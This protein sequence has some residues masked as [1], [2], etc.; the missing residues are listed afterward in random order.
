VERHPVFA[1]S[2]QFV[3]GYAAHRPIEA[4]VSGIP[5]HDHAW[6]DLSPD[7]HDAL[8]AWLRDVLDELA[9][10][11]AATTHEE[12][13]AVHVLEELVRSDLDDHEHGEH[14]RDLS[15]MDGT[16]PHVR[17]ALLS[18]DRTVPQGWDDTLARL[19]TLPDAL[20]GYR[21]T[22]QQGQDAGRWAAARQAESIVSQLR[23]MAGPEGAIRGLLDAHERAGGTQVPHAELTTAATGAGAACLALADDLEATYLPH[24]PTTDGVGE[25]RYLRAARHHLGMDLDPHEAYAWGWEHLA[26]L[27][28]RMRR[29]VA[30]IDPD[31]DVASVM[32]R[33]K[34]DPAH[35]AADADEF[36]RV[37]HARLADAVERLDGTH[38]AIPPAARRI[39][40]RVEPADGAIGAYY[41]PGSEDGTRPGAAVWE[42]EGDGPYP[43]YEE[44]STAYHEGF[45]G[46]HLQLSVQSTLTDRLSRAHRTLY[47]NAG[48]GEGWALYCERLMDELGFLDEPAYVVGYLTS[49]LLR[50]VRVVVDIGCHLGL[51]IPSDQPFH[52]GEPWNFELAVEMLE[53]DARLSPEY[54]R[55]EATRYLGMPAQAIT[56]QLGERVILELREE[57]RARD[58][59]AFDLAGFHARVLG[60][61]PVGLALLRELVLD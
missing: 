32:H 40:V 34:T 37:V 53:Q 60:N 50:A 17:I 56:Y 9:S 28:E 48:Y 39:D 33:L 35:C 20:R 38:V 3:D 59:D 29:T 55:S 13:L 58:G 54:A 1:L 6:D 36:V 19:R 4:T 14:T 15:H 5:G 27:R 7:G 18:M 57:L 46:H 24:A 8:A 25:E 42:L 43:L 52:P 41:V 51:R 22:L 2:D 21:R 10:L 23:A 44:I 11:P 30:A 12:R 49:A 45:P 47:W 26:R 16:V 61:G 31:G